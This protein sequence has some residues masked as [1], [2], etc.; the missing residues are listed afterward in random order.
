MGD[1]YEN[2]IKIDEIKSLISNGEFESAIN[3]AE[4]VDWSTIKN[5]PTLG[6]ISDLYKM[7]HMF[8]KS[9]SILYIAYD[10]QKSRP[11]L[12]SL[13]ELS[14]ELGDLLNAIEYYKEFR[15]IA[16]NDSNVFILKY[17]IYKAQNISIE[18][19]IQVLE[20]LKEHD[21][22]PKWSYELANLYRKAGMANKCVEE[23]NY[24]ILWAVDGKYAI[25]AYELKAQYEPLNERETFNYELLRQ[26]GG[27]LN[28][29]YSLKEEVKRKEQPKEFSVG[30]DISPYNTQNLQAVVAEGVQDY[31]NPTMPIDLQSAPV[32]MT[33]EEAIALDETALNSEEDDSDLMVTQMYNPV[34]PEAPVGQELEGQQ[35]IPVTLSDTDVLGD[36][37]TVMA[38]QILSDK[39]QEEYT[40]NTDTD[41]IK[42]ITGELPVS[43]IADEIPQDAQDVQNEYVYQTTYFNPGTQ[44]ST[45]NLSNTGIIETFHK[46]SNFD[47]ILS[48]G[49]DGQISF[50]VPENNTVERQ[51]TGQISID[52]VMLEWE[53]KKK[54]NEAKRVAEIKD[55]IKQQTSSLLDDF[56]ESTKS[57][58][59]AQIENAMINAALKEEHDKLVASRP[60]QIKVSD[61]DKA[62]VAQNKPVPV[63]QETPV[64]IIPDEEGIEE[65]E[66]ILDST[67]ELDNIVI[68]EEILTSDKSKA[69]EV[70]K[71]EVEAVEAP[72]IAEAPQVA[73][74]P[75]TEEA[76]QAVEEPAAE[77]PQAV[78]EPAA[79]EAPQAVEESAAEEAP[80]AVEEPAAEEAPQAVEEPVAEEAPQAVEEPAA[81]E[82]P[83]A[84]EEPAAEEAPQATVV[85]A[86]VEAPQTANGT[87]SANP[88]VNA[89]QKRKPEPSNRT[90]RMSDSEKEHFSA[91]VNQR[92]TEKQLINIL[93]NV[94]LAPYTGNILVSAEEISEV[95]TFSKLLIQE[96]ASADSNFT[97]KVA[98]ISGESLNRKDIKEA[99]EK[100]KNGALI[101]SEPEQ[102]KKK[103][104]E[105]LVQELNRD[106]IG[107]IIV[108]E[109]YADILDMLV[110]KNAGLAEAFNL[111]IDLKAFDDKTLVEYGKSYAY[112]REY[113]IDEL[114]SLALHTRIAEMQT[115][116]HEVTLAEI[117][118][119]VEDAIY[120]ANKKTPAHF[121]DILFGKRYDE[122][123]MI[124]LREKDFMHY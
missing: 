55:R 83:Q 90:R 103:T 111:R 35:E 109:G 43:Q 23:C 120:Y 98:Q 29:Q 54:E 39:V 15:Q 110:E 30:Q 119:L 11:I 38:S 77:A 95:T 9:R 2:K 48:Q 53:R 104:V 79:E 6:M 16:P 57:G 81:A 28:I 41:E 44:Y 97:G 42:P 17:K 3:I 65:I 118:E 82:V 78:E 96:I 13:C 76:P 12:K 19:Q 72:V 69:E 64:E 22:M 63:Q 71:E 86:E 59:L 107:V 87:K 100:V 121:F 52:D 124:V 74:E 27:E 89:P 70:S 94:T 75:A 60:K 91:F 45:N 105:S 21:F 108:I 7:A 1:K 58:L 116:D 24:L 102:L 18:E 122:Q 117:E 50:V 46:P 92:G 49:S 34:M 115:A 56:D 25:K 88:P 32:P 4:T 61:I 36:A 47:E 73:E 37:T 31:M 114:G 33:R 8:E 66:E 51:I 67:A 26:A 93:D 5:I 85:P 112:D 99:I 40:L 80:Q 68:P 106:D 101:I 62:D 20:E 10:K 14:I 113:V 123:D 84:V